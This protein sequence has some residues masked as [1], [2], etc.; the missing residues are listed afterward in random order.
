[1]FVGAGVRYGPEAMRVLSKAN[2]LL[3]IAESKLE[4]INKFFEFTD[5]FNGLNM[6]ALD[7]IS[8]LPR[9]MDEYNVSSL[10]EIPN[11][12]NDQELREFFEKLVQSSDNDEN[13]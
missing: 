4:A 6:T 13:S 11:E 3:D 7:L 10:S 5:G 9:L 2:N 8:R 1:M 12:L